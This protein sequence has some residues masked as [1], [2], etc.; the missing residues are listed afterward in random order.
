MATLLLSDKLYAN[1]LSWLEFLDDSQ[2]IYK[3]LSSKKEFIFLVDSLKQILLNEKFVVLKNTPFKDK[4]HLEAFVRFFGIY[5]GNVEHTGIKVNCNYTGCATN[6][7]TLHNDDAVDI[8]NQPS[9]G[10]IQVIKKDP[11]FK[12]ENG[13]VVIRELIRKLRFENPEL[14]DKL[15]TIKVPMISKGVNFDSDNKE[16]IEFESCILYKNNNEYKVRF[17]YDRVMYYY[18]YH[19]LKQS[20]EE[21]KMIYQFLQHCESLK[22]NILLDC[23]DILIHDNKAT[24]HDRTECSIGIDVDQKLITREILVSFAL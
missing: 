2:Q 8:K 12:V 20:H 5:Y 10:F 22:K 9:I 6:N 7:L 4:S 19:K 11:L 24:L 1:I 17:D 13:I 18:Q 15:L 3:L 21:G 14:L 23:G 16:I